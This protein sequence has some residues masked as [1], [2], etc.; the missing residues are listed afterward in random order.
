MKAK[1]WLEEYSQAV[2]QIKTTNVNTSLDQVINKKRFLQRDLKYFVLFSSYCFLAVIVLYAM[3]LLLIASQGILHTTEWTPTLFSYLTS[4]I[5]VNFPESIYDTNSIMVF[6]L[7]GLAMSG[8]VG[9]KYVRKSFFK[10]LPHSNELVVIPAVF[11]IIMLGVFYIVEA[12]STFYLNYIDNVTFFIS[13]VVFLT[14]SSIVFCIL[15]FFISHSKFQE[16]KITKNIPKY[17]ESKKKKLL[18]DKEFSENKELLLLLIE[19]KESFN[20]EQTMIYK[21]L[22]KTH[23]LEKLSISDVEEFLMLQ[24][25]EEEKIKEETTILND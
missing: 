2:K 21:D 24:N 1:K 19:K 20:Y 10:L 22:L 3:D 4:T 11:M 17:K 12:I 15:S 6:K 9:F 18:M 5:V 14:I 25:K 8:I 13:L 7:V 23:F 16:Y